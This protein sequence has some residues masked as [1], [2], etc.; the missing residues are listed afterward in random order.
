MKSIMKATILMNR[1][2]LFLI[3]LSASCFGLFLF[4]AAKDASP[5]DVNLKQ[6]IDRG[7]FSDAEKIEKSEVNDPSAPVTSE[8][9]IKHA[10]L[11]RTRID[12]PLTDKQVLAEI[13]KSIPDATEA[14]V[15][16]WRKA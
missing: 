2:R 1:I 11:R 9:A 7:D 5:S 6:L 8:A 4:G 13:K 10:V 12:Y 16:R 15:D 14:D 3:V